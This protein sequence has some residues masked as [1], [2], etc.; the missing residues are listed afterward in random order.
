MG[1]TEI[2]DG[3]AWP[4]LVFIGFWS[5]SVLLRLLKMILFIYSWLYQG[6]H[7]CTGF[8]WVALSCGSRASH[9]SDVSCYA[10]FSTCRSE[11][12]TWGSQLQIAGPIVVAHGP[13]CSTAHGIFPDQG[14]NLC[15]PHW[16]AD[17]LP[18]RHQCV[19]VCSKSLQ[20]CPVLCDPV[21]RSPPGSSV[22]GFSRQEYWSG[23]HFLL[24]R[25]FPTQGLNLCLTS[26]AL[27]GKIRFFT[28]SATWEVL[29]S[30]KPSSSFFGHVA[31]AQTR[32]LQV[33][34]TVSLKF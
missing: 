25:I 33:C 9:C 26:L 10:S 23:R 21:D 7:C 4:W 15:L 22:H 30:G 34:N 3:W 32:N 17:S 2:G 19:C 11:L 13:S 24:Q 28:T 14:L 5:E 12:H 20:L 18:L 16:Q 8:S 6:L 29:T 1:H 31:D 27:A